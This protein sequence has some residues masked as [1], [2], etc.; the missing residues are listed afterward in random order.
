MPVAPEHAWSPNTYQITTSPGIYTSGCQ[1]FTPRLEEV[2]PERDL[3]D[4]RR[5]SFV[6]AWSVRRNGSPGRR[7]TSTRPILRVVVVLA[8]AATVSTGVPGSGH[9]AYAKSG[10]GAARLTVMSASD[11]LVLGVTES[12]DSTRVTL[13]RFERKKNGWVRTGAPIPARLGPAGLAWGIGLSGPGV[14][15]AGDAR[16]GPKKTEGD[17]RAPAGV[18]ALGPVFGY[19]GTWVDRTDM[20]F[21]RVGPNDLF[22]ED[23]KSPLY[24]THVRLDHLPLTDWEKREQ[25]KQN[26]D[27]HRLKV[28]VRHNA[29]PPVAG[30]GSAVFL[31]V[32]RNDGSAT[33]TGCTAMEYPAIR[34]IVRWLRPDAQPVYVLLPKQVFREVQRTW[35]L[36]S[37]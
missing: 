24:N 6:Q 4:L 35:G 32:W 36:P 21:V 25:M 17:G 5:Q 7:S 3:L 26:D 23:P 31:H 2:Y 18:F 8:V 13:L 34:D 9:R 29:D 20:P 37:I 33:T 12:W 14:I 30:K 15:G 22:V 28:F 11:Q 1:Q 16:I 19:D 27:A 10:T